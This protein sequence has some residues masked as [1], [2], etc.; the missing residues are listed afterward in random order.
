VGCRIPA[1]G[2]P[3]SGGGRVSGLISG[4]ETWRTRGGGV[5][6]VVGVAEGTGH[7]FL[8]PATGGGRR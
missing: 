3:I 8:S 4:R 2:W 5:W 6:A 1:C 7:S